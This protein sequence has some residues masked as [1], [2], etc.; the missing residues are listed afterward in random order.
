MILLRF[1]TYRWYSLLPSLSPFPSINILPCNPSVSVFPL[2]FSLLF[3]GG[4]FK[5][6]LRGAGLGGF[7]P[8]NLGAS[9]QSLPYGDLYF[10]FSIRNPSIIILYCLFPPAPLF[11]VCTVGLSSLTIIVSLIEGRPL[12]CFFVLSLSL[13]DYSLYI[14]RPFFT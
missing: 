6:F 2:L 11:F 9:F 4:G 8:Y 7:S 5:G 13:L 12:L 3:Y 10:P 1:L 14:Y